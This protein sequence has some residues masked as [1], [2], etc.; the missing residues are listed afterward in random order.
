MGQRLGEFEL[1]V[2]LAALRL[3]PDEAYAVA[4]VDDIHERTGEVVRRANVYTALKRLESRGLITTRM[5][6]PRAERGGKARRL[7]SVH[8]AGI[9]AVRA[10]TQTISAMADGLE[11]L[12]GDPA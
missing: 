4:V 9:E 12:L 7:I 11:E 5:G 6:E 10:S 2:L 8:A 3:G 1:L